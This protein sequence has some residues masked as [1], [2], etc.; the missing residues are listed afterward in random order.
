MP[1]MIKTFLVTAFLA[2][3]TLYLHGL[4]TL[5]CEQAFSKGQCFFNVGAFK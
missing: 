5:A 3:S 2:T 1:T 4:E